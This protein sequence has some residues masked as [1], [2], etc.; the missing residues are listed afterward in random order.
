MVH[1]ARYLTLAWPGLPWLWLRGSAA[2]LVLAI[3]FAV[4]LDAAVLTTFIW[5]EI[6]ELRVAVGLWT[7]AAAIWIVA[8]VSAVSAFPPALPSGRDATV[9]AMFIAARDAYLS[10]DW[11]SAESKLRAALE[12]APTDGESQLLLA[13]LLRRVGRLDEARDA[14]GKLARSDAGAPWR[15]AIVRELDLL[16][17]RTERSSADGSGGSTEAGSGGTTLARAA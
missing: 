4:V 10:R 3:A 2:G 16:G 13:T 1:A 8:T 15:S 6:V 7:A 14:L 9:D 5:S 11:L 12:L 17:R